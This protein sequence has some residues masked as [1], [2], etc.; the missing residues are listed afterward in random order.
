MKNIRT[1]LMIVALTTAI[2]STS[3]FAQQGGASGGGATSDMGGATQTEH[4]TSKAPL[5][6]LLGLL[7]LMGLKHRNERV[8]DDRR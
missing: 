4:R 1:G 6:G 5:L 2:G 8:V 3:T 7:G